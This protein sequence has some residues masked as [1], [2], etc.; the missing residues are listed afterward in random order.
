M[1]KRSTLAEWLAYQ[2]GL[3]PNVIDMGLERLSSV[4]AA[5]EWKPLSCP[6]VTVGGTNGKGSCVALLESILSEQGYRVGAFTS[7]HLI[8]YNERIRIAGR[9]VSDEALI[10]AFERIEASRGSTSITF[11]EFNTLA[12]LLLFA[13]E[14]LDVVVLEVGLGGRLDAVNVVDSDVAIVS[15]IALDHCEWLGRDVESIGRWKAGI[16]RSGRPAIFGS[17]SM[18]NSIREESE[19]IGARLLRLGH[20]FDFAPGRG[21]WSFRFETTLEALPLPALPGAVQLENASSVLAAIRCLESRLPVTMDALVRGL[22]NVRLSGRFQIFPPSAGRSNEWILDVAHNPAAAATL[23]DNLGAR[24]CSGKT[25]AVCGM[26]ADKDVDGVIAALCDEIDEWV[27]A[28]VSGGRALSAERLKEKVIEA[29]GRVLHVAQNIEAAC[30]VAQSSANKSDRI[31]A[32]GSFHT[33]GPVL[34]WIESP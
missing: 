34:E 10:S 3:H 33:V 22:K 30:Q 29:G 17:R 5:L 19:R 25:I 8:R 21:A 32:F 1:T 4:L 24:P 26:F 31:V 18:P 23:A 7:P 16:F 9:E 14:D 20:E 13:K 15:S 28:T 27:I 2:E 6:V 12:A 11:F